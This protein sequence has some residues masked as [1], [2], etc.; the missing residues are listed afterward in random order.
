MTSQQL[1]SCPD[2][3]TVV[4]FMSRSPETN[5]QTKRCM[6][7]QYWFPKA[8]VRE[9]IFTLP[10]MTS[11]HRRQ[12]QLTRYVG[13]WKP[14]MHVGESTLSSSSICVFLSISDLFFSAFSSSSFF[15]FKSFWKRSKKNKKCRILFVLYFHY[16]DCFASHKT[17]ANCR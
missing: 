10:E 17:R 2:K 4:I 11:F 14:Q 6:Q 13:T 15:S 12:W 1:W 5:K 16:R 9:L 8:I 3:E 7:R